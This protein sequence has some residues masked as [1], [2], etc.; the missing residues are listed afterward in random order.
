M[1]WLR[2]QVVRVLAAAPPGAALTARELGR[3]TKLR[4]EQMQVLEEVLAALQK[5][6]LVAVVGRGRAAKFTL[7]EG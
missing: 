6:G 7:A 2:G 4:T 5:V 3:R 1:R